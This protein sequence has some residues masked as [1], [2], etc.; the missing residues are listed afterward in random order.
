MHVCFYVCNGRVN[1]CFCISDNCEVVADDQKSANF[2][3]RERSGS[4]EEELPT[5]MG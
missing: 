3:H 1:C 2:L 5:R 4:K